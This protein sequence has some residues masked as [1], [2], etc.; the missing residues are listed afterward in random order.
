MLDD[1]LS[2]RAVTLMM[3]ITELHKAMRRFV[4]KPKIP[5]LDPPGLNPSGFTNH[6]HWSGENGREDELA[7][8][9]LSQFHCGTTQGVER[10]GIILFLRARR[11]DGMGKRT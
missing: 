2:M 9:D 11:K 7:P 10:L 3:Q 5:G 1:R 8:A 4:R 6:R